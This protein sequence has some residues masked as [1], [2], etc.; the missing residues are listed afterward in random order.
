MAVVRVD[1]DELV[2]HGVARADRARVVAAFQ[3]EL[4]R[5]LL[6]REPPAAPASDGGDRR[7]ARRLPS[8]PHRL[9]RA[10]AQTVHETLVASGEAGVRRG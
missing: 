1:I 9:G 8:A 3:R 4:A 2:L 10:L 6:D 5:L 7:V